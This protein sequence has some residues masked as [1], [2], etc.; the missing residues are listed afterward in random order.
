M[1]GL[2]R[3]KDFNPRSPRGERHCLRYLAFATLAI[4]IHAPREGSDFFVSASHFRHFVFQSTLPARGATP[5]A[6]AGIIDGEISIHA[7]REGSD[8]NALKTVTAIIK[9]Q[10][11]LPA[12]GATV[13]FHLCL[14]SIS[15]FNPRSPRGERPR[16]C[17]RISANAQF[18]ST[19]PARGATLQGWQDHFRYRIS[20]HAP[21]EG[22]DI[23]NRG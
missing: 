4:S 5:C 8:P 7:P 15:Y 14:Q 12:R 1:R 21:R 22:S 18:Q 3:T 16:G 2:N 11:T 17:P 9:F 6:Y 13:V 20:I 10:S 19:L 23:F